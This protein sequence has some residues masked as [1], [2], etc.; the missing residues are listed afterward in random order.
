MPIKLLIQFYLLIHFQY[1]Q[2][3][4]L[5]LCS[6]KILTKLTWIAKKFHISLTQETSGFSDFQASRDPHFKKEYV[7]PT[8]FKH[9]EDRLGYLQCEAHI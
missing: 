8:I 4:H 2:C 7:D 3:L 9:M 1:F 6:L 5:I